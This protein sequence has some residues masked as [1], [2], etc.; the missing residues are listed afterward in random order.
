MIFVEI[1]YPPLMRRT[2]FAILKRREN[3][4]TVDSAY[5]LEIPCHIISVDFDL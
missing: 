5:F 3:M 1:R 4:Q 2:L